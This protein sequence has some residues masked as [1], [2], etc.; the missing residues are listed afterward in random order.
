M[1]VSSSPINRLLRQ[2]TRYFKIPIFQR[3]FSW[4]KSNADTLVEDLAELVA[5]KT[6]EHYFG[7]VVYQANGD[8]CIVI[9]GQQR[10][11]TIL[12]MITAIYHLI[13]DD[14]GLGADNMPASR[15]KD[16]YLAN[17]YEEDDTGR[18]RL[19]LR[20]NTDDNDIFQKI[21]RQEI[22]S[23]IM[24]SNLYRVYSFFAEHFKNNPKPWQYL[25]VLERLMIVEIQLDR[26]NDSAQ[27]IF[28]S[29]NAKG[30]SLTEADK[31]RN[32]AIMH[33]PAEDRDRIFDDYWSQIDKQL[34]KTKENKIHIAKFFFNLL[35][36]CHQKTPKLTTIY[37]EFKKYFNH[38]IKT[39]N[40]PIDDFYQNIINYL[41]HYSLLK[42]V[43][44]NQAQYQ[45]F[46]EQAFRINYLKN[47]I[48]YPF[49]MNVLNYH[50][51]GQ[52]SEKDTSAIFEISEGF[53]V[54]RMIAG[55]ESRN[56]T[57]FCHN[58]DRYIS[59]DQQLT[60]GNYRD[61]YICQLL[62]ATGAR[63]YPNQD[64][65]KG[66]I[67]SYEFGLNRRYMQYFVLSS[68]DDK[69]QTKESNVLRQIND[70]RRY[71]IE[72]IMPQT[73]TKSRF[74]QDELG[75]DWEN[76]HR[77][78]L[79]TLPNLTLTGYNS[80]YSNKSFAEKLNNPHGFNHSSLLLN[81]DSVA[82]HSVWNE[83][84][85][86]RRAQWWL[87]QIERL[88]PVPTTDFVSPR[89]KDQAGSITILK[90]S[91]KDLIGSKPINVSFRQGEKYV[92]SSWSDVVGYLLGEIYDLDN[93]LIA[94]IIA[95]DQL[96]KRISRYEEDFANSVQIADSD[97]FFS[98]Q[99][100]TQSKIDHLRSIF[101][102]MGVNPD[103]A[104]V[105]LLN[106]PPAE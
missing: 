73:I 5:D 78:Y 17:R 11:T 41:H 93:G 46:L 99:S 20:G 88:W 14:A 8:E 23:D 28:E 19:K 81:K 106:K 39:Q 79:Q 67:N 64:D 85:L 40:Q 15:I 77:R 84:T 57:S 30:E 42:F 22:S 58:L 38:Q 65:L 45:P 7:C 80:E 95:D 71:T 86:K 101:S 36:S 3:P 59:E 87:D 32:F 47:E 29:I 27:Q 61:I 18:E 43:E 55:L 52:L 97:Y 4:H 24:R 35:I 25:E 2:H 92:V 50:Q 26:D 82:V 100:N 56:I 70:Q 83:T 68:Y 21:Y 72:H 69:T 63:K 90:T 91:E 16:E 53:L 105:E 62:E 48:I 10:I 49:L 1:N 94:K 98:T 51:A 103:D 54:R 33:S 74:W 96:T 75:P 44:D 34:V 76:I 12:L 66:R 13:K 104:Q 102:L 89:T 60:S 6:K 31:I 37:S 9:D